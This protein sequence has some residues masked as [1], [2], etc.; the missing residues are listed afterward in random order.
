M[1]FGKTGIGL[2]PA[3]FLVGAICPTINAERRLR[4]TEGSRPSESGCQR[5]SRP[6]TTRRQP[7]SFI[8][9]IATDPTLLDARLYLATALRAAVGSRAPTPKTI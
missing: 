9:A 1:M 7:T 4:Q 2:K 5:L 6:A 8:I 3:A